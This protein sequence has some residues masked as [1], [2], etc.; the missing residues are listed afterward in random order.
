MSF[1]DHLEELRKRLLRALLAV[2]VAALFAFS[3]GVAWTQVGPLALPVPY[4]TLT[5]TVAASFFH[6]LASVQLPSGVRLAAIDPA[7][8]FTVHLLNS[9]FLGLAA[10]M[11]VVLHEVAAFVGPGLHEH[12]RR[13]L[14]R[15]VVPGTLLFLGGA[16]MA[17]FFVLPMTFQLLHLLTQ[18]YGVESLWRIT[19]FISLILLFLLAFGLIFQLPLLMALLTAAGLV[20]ARGW[21]EGWRI[22]VVAILVFA[23]IITPDSSGVTQLMV[24]I[25]MMALYGAGILAAGRMEKP[26]KE[27]GG[28]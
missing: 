21:R 24:A 26:Y 16:L 9:L 28:R 10:A 12:E 17:F 6:L 8:T 5:D 7:D 18:A 20:S 19:D 23:A 13:L 15:W 1:W 11:P 22:A 14:R 25:P 2:G 4:P 27:P 3:F